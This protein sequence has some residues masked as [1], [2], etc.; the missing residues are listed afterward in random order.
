MLDVKA[1]VCLNCY[2]YVLVNS[3]STKFQKVVAKFDEDH[4]L[5]MLLTMAYGEL[6]KAYV[7][8]TDKY[9]ANA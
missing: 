2:E 6:P 1:R 5:H 3:A 4:A 9:L 8:K 7:S